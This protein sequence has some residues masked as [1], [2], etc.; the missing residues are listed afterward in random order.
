MKV[1]LMITIG[2]NSRLSESDKHQVGLYVFVCN[3]AYRSMTANTDIV[4]NFN[5]RDSISHAYR[6]ES[7]QMCGVGFV[8]FW[9]EIGYIVKI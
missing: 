2:Y 3:N 7:A 8:Q 1:I 6:S 5:C 4:I 9:T